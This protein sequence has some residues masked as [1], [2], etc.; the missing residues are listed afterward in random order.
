MSDPVSNLPPNPAPIP[1]VALVKNSPADPVSVTQPPG[2]V[3]SQVSRN[4]S[5]TPPPMPPLT[6]L[7]TPVSAITQE[8]VVSTIKDF[9]KN[10]VSVGDQ[11]AVVSGGQINFPVPALKPDLTGVS[12]SKPSEIASPLSPSPQ[13][14]PD[15]TSSTAQRFTPAR[16]MLGAQDTPLE[17]PEVANARQHL[18]TKTSQDF[19]EY[20][21]NS[22]PVMSK[23][24]TIHAIANQIVKDSGGKLDQKEAEAAAVKMY[25]EQETKNAAAPHSSMGDK[26]YESKMARMGDQYRHNGETQQ[27]FQE[28][29]KEHSAI[30]GMRDPEAKKL[31]LEDFAMRKLGDKYVPV[32]LTRADG[33]QMV[34]AAFQSVANLPATGGVPRE[35]DEYYDTY[36]HPFKVI[37]KKA[38]VAASSLSAGVVYYSKLFTSL[39][40]SDTQSITGLLSVPT[41]TGTTT[42]GGPGGTPGTAPTAPTSNSKPSPPSRQ[43]SGIEGWIS[44]T[45]GDY[46]WLEV[47]ITGGAVTDAQIKSGTMPGESWT[48]GGYVEDDGATPPT[49]AKARKVIAKIVGGFAEQYVWSNLVLQNMCI[50]GRAA[51]YPVPY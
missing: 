38:N 22:G 12:F 27:Q 14:S 29:L 1:N 44:V 42:S 9:L 5:N 32:L 20:I 13:L 19:S 2:I 21:H 30:Q 36:T 33:R 3:P 49:Q 6:G 51:L 24:D 50:N 37:V 35:A 34:L 26:E 48:S 10:N 8:A 46:I 7:N 11:P 18:E 41:T 43:T 40:P 25:G 45:D 4:D 16:Q 31:A 47:S 23:Q 17:A 39:N 28:R 15:S